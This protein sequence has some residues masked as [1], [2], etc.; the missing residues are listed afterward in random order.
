MR[1]CRPRK[2]SIIN[3]IMSIRRRRALVNM[4]FLRRHLIGQALGIM[5]RDIQRLRINSRRRNRRRRAQ[6]RV[7]TQ[8]DITMRSVR[9][10]G[11][12]PFRQGPRLQRNNS[13]WGQADIITTQGALEALNRL[14][15]GNSEPNSLL[16]MV[17]YTNG[18][19]NLSL[20]GNPQNVSYI[21]QNPIG[22][23]Q[24]QQVQDGN[25]PAA[26]AAEDNNPEVPDAKSKS[27]GSSESL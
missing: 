18:R 5:N 16:V 25:D 11:R 26:Q 24:N 22:N 20:S 23:G 12:N 7:R 21:V 2:S 1:A 10:H 9:H 19:Y 4:Q 15:A 27:G 6:F 14:A 3:Q 17:Q 8:S 13:L